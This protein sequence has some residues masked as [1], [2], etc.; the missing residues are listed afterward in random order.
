M[1]D[2]AVLQK[3]LTQVDSLLSLTDLSTL[4][5]P[6]DELTVNTDNSCITTQVIYERL[7]KDALGNWIHSIL[8]SEGKASQVKSSQR[9]QIKVIPSCIPPSLKSFEVQPQVESKDCSLSFEKMLQ[10]M[11]STIYFESWY[12]FFYLSKNKDICKLISMKT[13]MFVCSP[14][15]AQLL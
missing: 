12:A 5:E 11:T 14:T 10:G 9:T 3:S 13:E 7:V 4:Q 6:W 8:Q 2:N 1:M 15:L